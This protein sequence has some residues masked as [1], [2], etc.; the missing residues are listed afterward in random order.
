MSQN[1]DDKFKNLYPGYRNSK[2]FSQDYRNW[3]D[4]LMDSIRGSLN[5]ANLQ[6]N[7]FATEDQLINQLQ[8]MSQSTEGRM[9]AAQI[10]NMIAVENVQQMR[11]LRQLQMAQM[12]AQNG[13]LASQNQEDLSK[14]AA[15]DSFF[16]IPDPTN[17]KSY[18]RFIG[19]S[20]RN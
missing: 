2:N 12:Q 3:S 13:Y 14:K 4:S 20:K 5:A 1:I 17:G 19:G 16:D 9:Q 18:K 11:K 7:D 8:N 6:A 15:Q 10:G